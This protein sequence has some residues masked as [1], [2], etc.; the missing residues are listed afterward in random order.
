MQRVVGGEDGALVEHLGSAGEVA[1][2]ALR[3]AQ[4][5]GGDVSGIQIALPERVEASR[6]DIG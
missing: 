5:A 2:H 6:K 1:R 4:D 3:L